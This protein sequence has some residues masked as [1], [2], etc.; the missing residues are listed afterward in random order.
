MA[1]VIIYHPWVYL[2]SGLERT[3]LEIAR[4]SRHEIVI[5]TSHY[6]AKGTYPEL[7]ECFVVEHDRVSV[8]RTYKEVLKAARSMFMLRFDPNS[9]D[10]LVISCDGLGPLL[11]FRNAGKPSVNL[12]FTPLRA[13]YDEVYRERIL[14]QG[15]IKRLIRLILESGFRILDRRAWRAFDGVISISETVTDRIVKGGLYPRE[16]VVLSF[17]GV[18]EAKIQPG[19]PAEQY[20]FL[21][22]RIM[23]TKNIELALEAF[24]KLRSEH[25]TWKL[26]IGGMV[27]AKSQEYFKELSERA[28]QI[29]NVTFRR[30]LSDAEMLDLYDRCACVVM[31]ALNEDQGLTPLEGATRGKPSIAINRGGPKELIINEKT[32]LLVEPDPDAYAEAM[33]R[34]INAPEDAVEMGLSAQ[35]HVKRYTWKNFVTVFDAE[36]DK[37]L[38]QQK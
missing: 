32:G 33:R 26:I 36:L 1:K 34:I 5:H 2:K 6:D 4:R 10:A 12:V 25:P 3:L 19:K 31:T 18:D 17:A 11:M 15:G 37:V 28:E 30:D 38:A 35:D 14:G 13:V 27:D 16:K 9:Y 23:W 22:G 8:K 20:F 7:L 29:G 24:E 21:P